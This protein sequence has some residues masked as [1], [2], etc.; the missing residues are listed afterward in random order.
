V[1]P[2]EAIPLSSDGNVA[3][4]GVLEVVGG[5]ISTFQRALMRTLGRFRNQLA[6]SLA[7]ARIVSSS[8][9]T[10]ASASASVSQFIPSQGKPT[11]KRRE[12]STYFRRGV[13]PPDTSSPPS[14]YPGVRSTFLSPHTK[15]EKIRR[16]LN[17]LSSM[18]MYESDVDG[19]R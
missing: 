15:S 3:V 1:G 14:L 6:A 10:S 5:S 4:T 13:S 8:T 19:I 11:V 18:E 17:H 9:P 16:R 7:S 12:S 2:V